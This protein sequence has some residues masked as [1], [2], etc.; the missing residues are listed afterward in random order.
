MYHNEMPAPDQD[1]LIIALGYADFQ[2]AKLA[3]NNGKLRA[4]KP[5]FDRR[6]RTDEKRI[7]AYAWRMAAFLV[8]PIGAHHCMPIGC[9]LEL[10]GNYGTPEY[11]AAKA[12]G[13]AIADA[14]VNAV[15]VTEWHGVARWRGLI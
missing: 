5:A 4:S 8:S 13:D 2:L 3:L 7:A 14:I 10:P 11:K 15:P 1:K 9:D 6:N 12:R